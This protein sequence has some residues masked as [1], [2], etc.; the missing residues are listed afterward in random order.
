MEISPRCKDDLQSGSEYINTAD[1]LNVRRTTRF[2][3]AY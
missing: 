1:L 2:R 3:T